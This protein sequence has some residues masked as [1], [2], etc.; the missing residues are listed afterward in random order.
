MT[1]LTPVSSL[2]S[3]VQLENNT[4]ALGGPGQPMNAQAQALLNRT[5]YLDDARIAH[6]MLIAALQA[7]DAD[8]GNAADVAKGV[9]FIGGAGRVVNSIAELKTLT[10]AS[11]QNVFAMSY[12]GDGK[13]GGGPYRR[14]APGFPGP[15]NDGSI[16]AADDG[17]FYILQNVG[18]VLATQFGVKE[19]D[20]GAATQNTIRMQAAMDSHGVVRIDGSYFY[21]DGILNYRPGL[22]LIGNAPGPATQDSLGLPGGTRL[23]F[24]GAGATCFAQQNT[25]AIIHHCGMINLSFETSTRD[26]LMD[27]HGMLGWTI[28][29][30]RMENTKTN[31]AGLR[32]QQVGSDPTWLNHC[33]DVEVRVPDASNQQNWDVDWSD[34]DLC[35]FALTGG[36]GAIDRGPGNMNYLGGI[37]DRAKASGAG[38]WLTG[39]PTSN[40]QTLVSNVKFDDNVGYGLVLDAHLNTTGVFAPTITGCVFRNP[41]TSVPRDINIINVANGSQPVMRGGTIVGNTFSLET[42][43]PFNVDEATWTGI[44]FGPNRYPDSAD[45]P[46]PLNTR[47]QSTFFGSNGAAIPKGPMIIRSDKTI[48]G[49]ANVSLFATFTTGDAGF[50]AGTGPAGVPFVGASRTEA[51]AATNLNFVTDNASRLILTGNG[52]ALHPS[53]DNV[54]SLGLSVNRMTVIYATTG[55][56]NT[57]DAREKNTPRGFSASE[58]EAA[59]LL[60]EEIGMWKFLS[61]IEAKGDAARWHVG[62]TVQRAIEVMESCG[63]DPMAYGFICY[64]E[65]SAV[66]AELD[67]EGNVVVPAI[68]AGNRYGFREN[69][70]DK[71]ILRGLHARLTAAGI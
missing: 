70:L 69:E 13:G 1:D 50:F 35:E 5:K 29:G 56:I 49:Q 10:V 60:S 21:F 25:G 14:A 16:I 8:L 59:K 18:S 30:V 31:G 9:S 41:D 27:M 44:T 55:A 43:T 11:N 71:F 45:T 46:F 28:S 33:F 7:F 23:E 51:G 34:S 39:S 66:P 36:L 67:A 32:S 12:W 3:V 37:C 54:M 26:R 15:G 22:F 64:D 20:A 17:G 2:D 19:N 6:A 58:I 61:S 24:I 65:W 40:K 47:T 52:T 63:L 38:L 48:R 53:T 62:M 4:L 68:E 42:R 57:S